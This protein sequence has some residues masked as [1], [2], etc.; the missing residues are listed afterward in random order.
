MKE[1]SDLIL[2]GEVKQNSWKIRPCQ[3]YK[4]NFLKKLVSCEKKIG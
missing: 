1:D 3:I 4:G 2:E